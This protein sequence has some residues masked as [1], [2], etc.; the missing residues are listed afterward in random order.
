MRKI[1]LDELGL[2]DYLFEVQEG[3]VSLRRAT[4]EIYKYLQK[5]IWTITLYTPTE[6]ICESKGIDRAKLYHPET[7]QKISNLSKELGFPEGTIGFP[8]IASRSRTVGFFFSKEEAFEAAEHKTEGFNEA[9]YY[10]YLII[11]NYRPSMWC[12]QWQQY[13][14]KYNYEKGTYE[15]LE[16]EPEWAKGIINFSLG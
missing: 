13:F 5:E 3:N 16:N 4:K 1:L 7:R 2:Q 12:S 6:E 14:F 11:G 15:K 8:G 9:G 10:E